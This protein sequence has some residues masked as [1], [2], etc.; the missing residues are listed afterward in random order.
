MTDIFISYKREDRPQVERLATALRGLGF[1][2]WFDASLSAGESF[3]D[4]ID[5]AVRAAKVV[6]VCWSPAAAASQWVK[7]EAQIG[8][9]NG[10]LVSTYIEGPDGFDA[11]VPFN[12]QH[13]EDMR[14]WVARPRPRDAAWLSVLRRIG[15][16]TGRADVAEWGALGADA[17]ANQIEA[18]MLAHG[19]QSPLVL[20]A[21]SFLREREA[22]AREREAGEEAARERVAR[23]QAEKQA[24]E[25]AARAA[26]SEA[27]SAREGAAWIQP[28]QPWAAAAAYWEK[29][30]LMY[31]LLLAA[32]VGAG[33]F[34]QL[35]IAQGAH[36]DGI[37]WGALLGYAV[38]ANVAYCAAYPVDIFLQASPWRGAIG[39]TR[40][41]VFL[42]GTLIALAIAAALTVS[43]DNMAWL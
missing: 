5:R 7:A 24:A 41:I 3:S 6:L 37:K 14:A 35:V 26:Q 43:G 31:N 34:Y 32:L 1:D 17:S 13:I 30:R 40:H 27:A 39:H 25:S 20:E 29:M 9:A 11:P 15:G 4:E 33:A 19:A 36:W 42:L 18:W 22:A 12:A 23:L 2:T 38:G 16:L 28:T 8:F 10:A 21:E